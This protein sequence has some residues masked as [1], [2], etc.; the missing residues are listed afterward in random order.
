MY[1]QNNML[2]GLR[3]KTNRVSW[4]AHIYQQKGVTKCRPDEEQEEIGLPKHKLRRLFAE[5]FACAQLERPQFVIWNSLPCLY[6]N[7]IYGMAYTAAKRQ[8]SSRLYN[9]L[10]IFFTAEVMPY[11]IQ[12]SKLKFW[13]HKM[14]PTIFHVLF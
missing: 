3:H 7:N 2:K 12:F 1:R 14:A 6:V 8:Q 10:S 13:A 4:N 9:F 11:Y 5:N